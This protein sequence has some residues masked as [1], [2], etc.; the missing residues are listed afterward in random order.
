VYIAHCGDPNHSRGLDHG[1]T[2]NHRP[3]QGSGDPDHNPV[4][5]LCL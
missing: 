1:L 2:I 4:R 5:R 3:G